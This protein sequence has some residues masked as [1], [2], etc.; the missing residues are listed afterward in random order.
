MKK[1]IVSI[2]DSSVDLEGTID[3]VIK[4]LNMWKEQHP[5]CLN[6]RLEENYISDESTGI[7]LKYDR[8]ETDKEEQQRMKLEYQMEGLYRKQDEQRIVELAKK[9]NYKLIPPGD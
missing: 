1:Q 5:E 8:M 4:R 3:E 2:I 7:A 9:L 6:L